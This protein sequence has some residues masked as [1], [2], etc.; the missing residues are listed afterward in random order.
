MLQSFDEIRLYIPPNYVVLNTGVSQAPKTA[1]SIE[2]FTL[3]MPLASPAKH[4]ANLLPDTATNAPNEIL[5]VNFKDVLNQIIENLNLV[6]ISHWF[7]LTNTNSASGDLATSNSALNLF[8]SVL[9]ALNFIDFNLKRNSD[10]INELTKLL[11][12]S[13]AIKQEAHLKKILKAFEDEKQQLMSSNQAVSASAVVAAT[14]EASMSASLSQP[15]SPTIKPLNSQNDSA[16]VKNRSDSKKSK[17]FKGFGGSGKFKSKEHNSNNNQNSISLAT[18][19]TN[20]NVNLNFLTPATPVGGRSPSASSSQLAGSSS[21]PPFNDQATRTEA[22]IIS[23]SDYI[24]LEL[25][26]EQISFNLDK[27]NRAWAKL[28]ATRSALSTAQA[29]HD[30]STTLNYSIELQTLLNELHSSVVLGELEKSLFKLNWL[31]TSKSG[32]S[33]PN[34]K[35]NVLS[36]TPS[37]IDSFI[38]V[39]LL[40]NYYKYVKYD[41]V[42]YKL[43]TRQLQL[44]QLCA[45]ILSLIHRILNHYKETITL[46]T[47]NGASFVH[48]PSS[49][50]AL[51]TGQATATTVGADANL[52]QSLLSFTFSA[53]KYK[54]ISWSA[55]HVT[56]Y[57]MQQP[58][59]SRANYDDKL[60]TAGKIKKDFFICF[61]L[62]LII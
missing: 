31:I 35:T 57:N 17:S 28:A 55:N 41:F 11:D 30:S 19:P 21:T 58:N 61:Q 20:P 8:D 47:L 54:P 38:G 13:R 52:A 26:V 7:S 16:T 18:T 24:E 9:Q 27:L 62:L 4:T 25:E 49:T 14:A 53:D 15:A 37:T 36:L 29:L 48:A 59:G 43:F 22:E 46:A 10:F 34:W 50:S 33:E 56:L 1:T 45:I 44:I 12:T 23:N 2:P 42:S 5:E 39:N 6:Q 3:R 51:A 40:K 60:L 32:F